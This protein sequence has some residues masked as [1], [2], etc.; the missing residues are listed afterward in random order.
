MSTTGCCVVSLLQERL[1]DA[2]TSANAGAA[3]RSTLFGRGINGTGAAPSHRGLGGGGPSSTQGVLE[4][5]N[6]RCVGRLCIFDGNV[7]FRLAVSTA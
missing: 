7:S 1:P 4:E 3:A 6:D 5:D 2:S